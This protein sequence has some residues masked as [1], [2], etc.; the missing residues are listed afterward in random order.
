M[1]STATLPITIIV[2]TRNS[3]QT[4]E[5]CLQSLPPV[6]ELLV[7]DMASKD[8]SLVIARQFHARTIS[9]VDDG[10]VEPARQAAIESATQP[11]ILIVDADESL[12]ADAASWLGELTAKG[13]HSV[14]MLPRRNIIFG[15]P[16]THTGWWPDYQVRLF[17]KGSVTW[18][19]KIHTKPV[20]T[21]E[22]YKLP[23]NDTYAIIH[24]N[25]QH[26]DQ[27][28]DRMNHYTTIEANSADAN[29]PQQW[30]TL[31]TS[32]LFSRLGARTGWLDKE[33]GLAASLLQSFYPFVTALKRWESV[34]F[35]KR[36]DFEENLLLQLSELVKAAAY[37]R[38][39]NEIRQ[40]A[41]LVQL[42]WRIRRKLQM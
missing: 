5:Q 10:F 34:G 24:Q 14:I 15:H 28:I 20:C 40:T 26:I 33:P 21:D 25:Y 31:M 11:W 6:A 22:P 38:A 17:Q 39:T 42:F 29:D 23:A 16:F 35:P 3:G 27:F 9:V 19:E 41:G 37:W 12:P 8:E 2:H 4:L 32:E 13:E 36:K 18:P 1:S 7:V 30:L